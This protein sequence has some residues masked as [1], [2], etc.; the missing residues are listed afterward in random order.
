MFYT[1]ILKSREKDWFYAGYTEDLK[2]R[3]I[4]HQNGLSPATKPYRPFSLIFYEAFK[5]KADAKRREKY[6]KTNK[7]KRALNLMLKESKI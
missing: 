4:E 5:S 6:F 1:Y 3:F 2:K 7:G